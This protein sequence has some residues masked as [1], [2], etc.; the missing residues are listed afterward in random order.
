MKKSFKLLSLILVFAMLLGT[1]AF[2]LA[3]CGDTCES[4]VDENGDGKCDKCEKEYE[5]EKPDVPPDPPAEEG[6]T[7]YT[8]SVK[9]IGG[10]AMSDLTVFIYKDETLSDLVDYCTTDENGIATVSL[11][12]SADYAFK[13][14]GAPKGYDIADYYTFTKT[15]ANVVLSSSV[16]EEDKVP[17]KYALGDIMYDF[18]V[19]TVDGKKFNLSETL[20]EKDAVL[21]NFWFSTCS[22]CINEFPYLESAASKYEDIAVI[23]LNTYATDDEEAVKLFKSTYELSLD[24]AK[25]DDDI[26]S[27]FGT[28]GYPTSVV[29]DKYG[30]ICLIEVGGLPSE[31]PFLAVFDHFTSD[32]YEQKLFESIDELTPTKEPDVQMP[33]SETLGG[34]LNSGDISVAYSAQTGTSDAKYSWPFVIGEKN[35]VACV[36]TSN[37]FVDS[38]FATLIATFN[39]KKGEVV[40]FDYFSS[41]ESGADIL[42]VLFDGEAMIEIS[43][44]SQTE[45]KT[46][47]PFVATEDGEYVLTFI[48]NKDNSVDTADDTVYLKNMRVTTT[49]KI[50]SDTYIPYQCATDPRANGDGFESYTQVVFNKDDGYYHVCIEEH[51]HADNVCRDDGPLLLANLMGYTP[52][53]S[54][55]SVFTYAYNGKIV[56][57]DGKNYYDDIVRYCNY[58]SN[59]TI[60]GLCTVNEELKLLLEKIVE[61]VSFSDEENQWLQFCKYYRAYGKGTAELSDPIKGLA[62]HSAFDTVVNSEAGKDEYPNTVTYDRVIMPR[63][64]W[65]EFKP[66]KSGVYRIVSNSKFEVDGWIFLADGTELLVHDHI[67][68]MNDDFTNVNMVLYFEEGKTY[69]IDIAY[70]DIYQFGSFDF[71]IEYIADTYENFRYASSGVFTYAL[72]PDGSV[73]NTMIHGGIDVIFDEESGYF[74]EKRADGSMG[75]IIFADFTLYTAL[76]SHVIYI[77]PEAEGLDP[78]DDMLSRGAFDF[79]GLE[80]TKLDGTVVAGTDMTAVVEA[81][82]AKMISPDY[83]VEGADAR[84]YGCVAVDMQ[85]AEILQNTVDRY[86]FKNVK[87]SWTKF[88]Y[89]YEYHGPASEAE[90]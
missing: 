52:F 26:F 44:D 88:C 21:I 79:T 3:S 28:G 61:I 59:A 4:H 22:P 36:K 42:Y 15:S 1:L 78:D 87:D 54:E 27:A 49:D 25:A 67:E 40:A 30:T 7:T 43:G 38:S 11:K 35:G 90:A 84:A 12:T 19:T 82:V 39:L 34:V 62:P 18:T 13:I 74:R 33:D 55:D 48:Y 32:N 64:L 85:L 58:A 60:G 10:M 45:W 71:K 80:Y 17:S 66:E 16:I 73:S 20:E 41:T 29:V 31:K 86:S 69:Y 70:Y 51:Q 77:D 75:S 50:D 72:N 56:D 9:S 81:Y 8:V 24:M 46:A 37:A 5:E 89:Y 2:T 65:Y 53:S 57:A 6:N 68:R 63:G 23:A 47:Y 76:F 14:S 83:S